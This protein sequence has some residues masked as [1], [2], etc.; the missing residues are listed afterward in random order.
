MDSTFTARRSPVSEAWTARPTASFVNDIHSGLNGT[1]VGRIHRPRSVDELREIVTSN[2]RS[3]GSLSFCGGRHA[4]GGQQFATGASLIDMTLL[5]RVIDVDPERG[6]VTVE[7]GIDWPRLMTH[8]LWTFPNPEEAWSIV[9]KQT[10]ADRLTIGGALASN[11]HGRGLRMRP[12]VADVESFELVDAAGRLVVCSRNERP[13]LFSLAI[14]GYG[15]F[16]PVARVTLRLARRRKVRR[17]VTIARLDQLHE[18]FDL[19]I[20]EG[21]EYGDF[22]FATDS[23]SETFLQAGVFSCYKPVT[24]DVP[25]PDDQHTLSTSEW[26]RLLRLAHTDKSRAFAAY[27]RHYMATDGQIYWSD[28][29][30][31][32]DYPEGYHAELDRELGAA[33]TGSEMISELYVPRPCL[34]DFMAAVRADARQH[35]VDVIYGTIRLIERDD[36]S[37]LAWARDR[38]ACIVFNLHVDHTASGIARARTDFRRLIDRAMQFGGSYYLTYHR[39]ASLE[40]VLGCHPKLPAFL[41][42]KR[43]ADPDGVFQSDWYSHHTRLLGGES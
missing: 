15:L 14:G 36:E 3:G 2:A 1:F 6:L 41:Q 30:Q 35:D 27:A 21:F 11:I 28:T 10:G 12:F 5:D 26:R 7:A 19:R 8:L 9:Q 31:L 22:Q 40:Q 24:L 20:C 16:G 18:L 37:F 33:V 39:W 4:M 17:S 29:H 13:Q 42:E 23:R 25:V 38:W 34:S 32:S 43:Q